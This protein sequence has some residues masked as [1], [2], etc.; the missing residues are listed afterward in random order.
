MDAPEKSEAVRREWAASIPILSDRQRPVQEW[1]IYNS[2]E[3]GGI[4]KPAPFILSPDLTVR[5]V[6]VD[7]VASGVPAAE[8]LRL[9]REGGQDAADNRKGIL[10]R[11]PNVLRRDTE[12]LAAGRQARPSE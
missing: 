8:I 1:D 9:L 10:P 4:A 6:S 5:F 11:A 3:K 7:Q 2:R 12:C